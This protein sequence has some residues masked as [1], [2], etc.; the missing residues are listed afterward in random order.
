MRNL[1]RDESIAPNKQVVFASY[2]Y[3]P[4]EP[5][6]IYAYKKV[7]EENKNV[8]VRTNKLFTQLLEEPGCQF[9]I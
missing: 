5:Y 4:I 8:A 1:Y 9:M 7:S 3:N 2:R 6:Q